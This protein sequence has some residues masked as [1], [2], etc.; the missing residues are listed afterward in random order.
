MHRSLSGRIGGKWFA[1]SDRFATQFTTLGRASVLCSSQLRSRNRPVVCRTQEG[2]PFEAGVFGRCVCGHSKPPSDIAFPH[3]SESK[4]V[5]KPRRRNRGINFGSSNH[6]RGRCHLH[7]G[8]AIHNR[9]A[10]RS[11]QATFARCLHMK[12]MSSSPVEP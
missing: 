9:E 3:W 4:A 6:P 11:G 8:T 5:S 12:K 2:A 1:I 7:G 10:R